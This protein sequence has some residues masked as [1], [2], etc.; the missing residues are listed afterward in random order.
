MPKILEEN[1]SDT[2]SELALKKNTFQRNQNYP[3]LNK[4]M[5]KHSARN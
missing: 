4:T 3:K 2:I 5:T 1:V